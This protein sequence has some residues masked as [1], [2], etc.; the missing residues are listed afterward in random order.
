MNTGAHFNSTPCRVE[1]LKETMKSRLIELFTLHAGEW[2]KPSAVRCEIRVENLDPLAW[3]GRQRHG[4]KFYFSGRD[5]EDM[6]VSGIGAADMIRRDS[7]PD[8][9]AIFPQMRG[10]LSV[11]YPH[12]KYWG[13]F[14]FAPGHIDSDWISF[15]AARFFIPRFEVFQHHGNSFFACN[16]VIDEDEKKHVTL[17]SILTELEEVDFDGFDFLTTGDGLAPGLVGRNDLPGR[18]EWVKIIGTVLEEI[19]EKHYNKT[20]LARK[21]VLDFEKTVKPTGVLSML[22]K[23]L[24][25]R[26]DFLFQFDGVSAFVGS[27]PERLYKRVGRGILSEAVAGTRSRGNLEQEDDRLGN[28]LMKSDKEQREHD[29]VAETIERDLKSLCTSLE[30][31]SRKSLMKLK[32]GQ[33][34]VTKLKGVLASGV[35][36]DQLVK[37]LHPTPAVGGCPLDRALE[38]I[39]RFEPFKRG[40]YAGALGSVGFDSADFCVGLRSALIHDCRVSLFSGVGIVD[41]SNAFDEWRELECKTRNFMEIL[42]IKNNENEK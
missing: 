26:Y 35:G 6:R 41:G 40:W 12:L 9:E 22:K 24:S 42:G 5:A 39:R 1:G 7:S 8:Y 10:R 37:N 20:V 33:H 4:M 23:I 27:S 38:A 13:G 14:A 31:D 2:G 3:L 25:D 29:F 32:E 21:V 11:Q 28:E 16:A 30:K 15:G 18:E 17:E 34:L 36:D 19:R